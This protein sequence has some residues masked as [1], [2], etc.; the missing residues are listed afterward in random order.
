MA[1]IISDV[2]GTQ[3]R[4]QQ[5][6]FE[7]YKNRFVAAGMSD[8]MAQGMTDMAAKNEGI[9]NAVQQTAKNS[10]P[11]TF[12]QWCEQVLK[13][14]VTEQTATTVS[15]IRFGSCQ[16]RYRP[17]LQFG[18]APPPVDPYRAPVAACWMSATTAAGCET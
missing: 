9:D 18:D 17:V 6:T 11:T 13:P 15:E 16:R 1:E 10:T 2:L 3:L 8:V 12:R 7:A 4:F 5:T 14:A